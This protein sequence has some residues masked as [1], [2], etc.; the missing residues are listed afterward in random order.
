[1][2]NRKRTMSKNSISSEKQH[3]SI[4]FGTSLKGDVVSN[5][6][7]RV[8]GAIEGTLKC[9][10]KLVLGQQGKIT[11]EVFCA[12]AEILGAF[13]GKLTVSQLLSLKATA[14]VDGEV[15]TGKVSIE[16]GAFFNGSCNMNGSVKKEVLKK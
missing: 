4:A 7:F 3:N 16:P 14:K 10:G 12:N 6:D 11:G 1:M 8:D 15:T 2:L 5:G 9:E 13:N